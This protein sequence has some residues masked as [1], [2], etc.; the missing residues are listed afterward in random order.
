MDF[1]GFGD[2]VGDLIKTLI[3]IITSVTMFFIKHFI[4]GYANLFFTS[5]RYFWDLVVRLFKFI[6][7]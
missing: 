2:V 7:R 3:D 1:L 5:L 6:V 4:K